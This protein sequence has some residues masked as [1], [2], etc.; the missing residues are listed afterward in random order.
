M[1]AAS[2]E[3]PVNP[4]NRAL[5]EALRLAQAGYTLTPVTVTRRP[6]G[7]KAARF[8]R[9]SWR[10]EGD[11][12]SDP[13]V[14][15]A[16]WVDNP[17]TS[18][19]LV[20]GPSGVEGVDLDVK[21]S[22]GVDAVTWWAEQ[23]LPMGSLLVETPSGGMHL[24]WRRRADGRGLP[25]RA[26]QLRRGVDTRNGDGVFF[27][28]G[29]YI[30]G[31]AGSY[32]VQ[33]VLP[34]V[35][36]LDETPEAVLALFPATVPAKDR[37]AN[38]E[39]T[40]HT[41]AWM[42]ERVR[43][44]LDRVRGHDRRAGGYRHVLM[45]AAM[46]AGRLVEAGIA[47]RTI[48]VRTLREATTSVWGACD[49]E[50]EQ[51]I[52]DGLRDGPARER[53]R[54]RDERPVEHADPDIDEDFADLIDREEPPEDD[55]EVDQEHG[56]P[57][58]GAQ[59]A[60]ERPAAGLGRFLLPREVW[61]CSPVMGHIFRAAM[62]RISCPDTVLHAVLTIV[63]SQLHHDSRVH[64]GKRP[65][66]LSYYFAPVAESGGG[67]SE[68][69]AAARDLMRD[70]TAQRFAI[71]G[72][73][74]Y[75]DAPLGSGEGLIEAFQ[76]ELYRDKV[77]PATGEPL[78]DESGM[79][80]QI[81]VRAQVRHNALFHTDEGRQ[82]LAI[83]S[84]KGSTVLGVLCELWSGAVAGQTNAD[85]ERCRKLTEG[86]YV[87][88]VLLGFQT[89]TIDPL[90]ADEAGGAPQRFAFAPAA[91]PAHADDL[92][93]DEVPWPGA[94]DL[95]IP[96]TA[97][98]VTLGEVQRAEVRRHVRL[99]AAGMSD[100]GPLDG[101]RML[102]KCRVAAL[103]AL[104]HGERE[105][106]A[107]IWWLAGELVD[108]SCALRDHLAEGGR[109]RVAEQQQAQQRMQIETAAKA[110]RV[111]RADEAVMRAA[112]QIVRAVDRAGGTETRGKALHGIRSDLRQYRDRALQLAVADGRLVEVDGGKSLRIGD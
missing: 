27:A 1:T 92:D 24:I 47:D 9:P 96:P 49:A 59:Q 110:A 51:W 60:Q 66:V 32:V 35:E 15:R 72:G 79:P 33:G 101:H 58:Q 26:G 86:T 30:V 65:S 45:G 4:A 77:D 105:V 41:V 73:D 43:E 20:C 91:Y 78:L 14:I 84:R 111:T 8:H 89:A 5:T 18:F 29:G 83:D 98:T 82:V 13:E 112:A 74:G 94:L 48:A 2:D 97:V 93:A 56:R 12:S 52:Q 85:K 39:I 23:G 37:P 80:R 95:P 63:A 3:V 40:T 81:K 71:T 88:G 28:A 87:V 62:S 57:E 19:A 6:D 31:E 38:G 64:T 90:F 10:A 34:R 22:E 106:S 11:V 99:R 100:D 53:W 44:Q 46:V 16:W 107:D 25:N 102:L 109:R 7:K 54:S 68:A 69:L 70:W 75:I 55:P 103:L 76:G 36:Q 104:L 67:K 108:R 61:D 21:P 42:N 50:D 17:D